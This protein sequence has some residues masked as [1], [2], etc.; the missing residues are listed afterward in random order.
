MQDSCTALFKNLAVKPDPKSCSVPARIWQEH[1]ARNLQDGQWPNFLKDSKSYKII[2][3]KL[4][5]DNQH[6]VE[7]AHKSD[8]D[9]I[10]MVPLQ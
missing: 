3:K 8:N 4:Q 10:A 1:C 9:G 7:S 6:M 2:R 5:Q